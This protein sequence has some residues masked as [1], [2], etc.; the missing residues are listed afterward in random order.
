MVRVWCKEERQVYCTD[1]VHGDFE[2]HHPWGLMSFNVLVQ[3][4]EHQGK[5]MNEEKDGKPDH[6]RWNAT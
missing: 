1:N 5:V 2:Q 6:S 4:V 3:K